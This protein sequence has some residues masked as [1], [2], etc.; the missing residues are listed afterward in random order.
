MSLVV[1][2]IQR[3]GHNGGDWVAQLQGGPADG[4]EIEGT[5]PIGFRLSTTTWE[6][7]VGAA[8][9]EGFSSPEAVA[10]FVNRRGK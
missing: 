5:W 10:W 3:L 4:S 9:S 6:S 7:S 2:E 1:N 8:G